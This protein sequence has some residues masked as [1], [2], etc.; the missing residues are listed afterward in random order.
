MR[1]RILLDQT[2]V[3][4]M[5]GVAERHPGN[6]PTF[7]TQIELDVPCRASGLGAELTGGLAQTANADPC[8][9]G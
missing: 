1:R 7:S 5:P 3:H 8:Y 4:A 6:E 2:G 9:R